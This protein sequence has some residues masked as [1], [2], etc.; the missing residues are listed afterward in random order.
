MRNP[1]ESGDSTGKLSPLLG[2]PE[3]AAR[4]RQALINEGADLV[5]ENQRYVM[6]ISE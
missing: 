6:C 1:A 3:P 2:R 4:M 5:A